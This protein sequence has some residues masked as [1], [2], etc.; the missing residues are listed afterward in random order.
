M[1]GCFGA[2]LVRR[3]DCWELSAGWPEYGFRYRQASRV[4][5]QDDG[6]WAGEGVGTN[7]S[8]I[9]YADA[10]PRQ[11]LRSL[12]AMDRPAARDLVRRLFPEHAIEEAGDADLMDVLSPDLGRAYAGSYPAWRSCAT[13]ALAATAPAGFPSTSSAR[14]PTAGST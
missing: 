14:R 4:P 1:T 2:A 8:L 11:V 6:D 7:A 9:V 10:D 3:C 13:A 12:P 5:G